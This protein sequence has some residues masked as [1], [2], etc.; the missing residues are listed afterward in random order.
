MDFGAYQQDCRRSVV[1]S[2]ADE[3]RELEDSLLMNSVRK[4]AEKVSALLAEEFCEFG[5]SGTVYSKTDIL[6]FL[7]DEEETRIAMSDFVYRPIAEGVALVTYRSERAEPDGELIAA[8]RSSLWVMRNGR[9]QMVFH[10]GTRV[11]V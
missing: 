8:L 6:A 4:D 9:W 10:Q 7:R 3:L 2:I 5:R 1:M 11:K